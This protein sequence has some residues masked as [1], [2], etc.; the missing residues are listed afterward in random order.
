VGDRGSFPTYVITSKLYI[1]LV[2]INATSLFQEKAQ[3]AHDCS[4]LSF[5]LPNT[6]QF[7]PQSSV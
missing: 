5:F 6:G 7:N 3:S 1:I 2:N 4:E